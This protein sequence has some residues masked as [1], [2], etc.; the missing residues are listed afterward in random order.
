MGKD[1]DVERSKLEGVDR[2]FTLCGIEFQC[3]PTMPARSLS[4]LA[5]VQSGV[6]TAG[7]YEAICEVI[8]STIR[9]EHREAWD[10]LLERDDLAVPIDMNTLLQIAD[11]LCEAATGRPT[12]PPSPSTTTPKKTP[13]GSTDASDSQ[14][15]AASTRSLSVPV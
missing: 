14:A 10:D 11:D 12:S 8:R 4:M 5:D 15:E 7:L 1:Y 13:I 2:S 6:R 3:A 9:P